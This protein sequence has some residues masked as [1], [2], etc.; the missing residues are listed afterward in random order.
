MSRILGVLNYKG[1][2]GK[3]TTVVNLAAGLALRGAR[4]LCLDLDPQG[5]LAVYLGV[6]YIYSLADLLLQQLEPLDCIVPVRPNLDII[7]SDANLLQIEGALWRQEDK[8]MMQTRLIDQLRQ[9]ISPAGRYDFIIVDYSPSASLLGE[10]S[11]ECIEELIV[12]VSMDYAALA[13]MQRVIQTVQSSS[14]AS[15]N[16]AQISLIVPTL[17]YERLAKDRRIVKI[18]K[19]YFGHRVT[20]PIRVNVKLSAASNRQMNIYD[21]DPCSGGAYDYAKLVERVANDA[22]RVI[23]DIE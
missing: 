3:T 2:V 1:R 14:R 11:L 8:R 19:H 23:S 4:V 22:L 10:G 5:S 17:Y 7:A 21:Y 13:G 9:L 15:V 6:D 20:D 18:L 16:Q 12:P